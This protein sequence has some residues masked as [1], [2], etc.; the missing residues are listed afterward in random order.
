MSDLI[1]WLLKNQYWYVGEC[2]DEAKQIA[3][4]LRKLEAVREAALDMRF[5]LTNGVVHIS[6]ED[7][8]KVADALAACGDDDG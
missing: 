8:D 4:R 2:P 3:E 1:E 5:F 7:W 6:Q